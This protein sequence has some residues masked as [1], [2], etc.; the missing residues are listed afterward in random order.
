MSYIESSTK[1]ETNAHL[2]VGNLKMSGGASS[3][4]M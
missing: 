1:R 4:V 3:S 2:A